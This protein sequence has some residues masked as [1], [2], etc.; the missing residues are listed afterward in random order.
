MEVELARPYGFCSGVRRIIGL[1]E[2]ALQEGPIYSLGEPIHNPG[3]VARLRELGL[4]I[5]DRLAGLPQDGR[6]RRFL[7]RAHGISPEVR[8]EVERRGFKIIDGTCPL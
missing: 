2:R 1:V 8:G 3:E 4:V 5:V 7:V 6:G